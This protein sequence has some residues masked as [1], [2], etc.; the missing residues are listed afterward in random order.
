MPGPDRPLT[1]EAI[2]A[3]FPELSPRD[4]SEVVTQP[5]SLKGTKNRRMTNDEIQMSKE[6]RMTKPEKCT[7]NLFSHSNFVIP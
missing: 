5:Q 7:A 1:F 3:S 2:P 6:I 4:E